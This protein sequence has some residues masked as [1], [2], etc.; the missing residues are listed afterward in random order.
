MLFLHFQRHSLLDG[1]N[2]VSRTARRHEHCPVTLALAEQEDS[3]L[4]GID[5][6]KLPALRRRQ[7]MN[8]MEALQP[9]PTCLLLLKDPCEGM[10]IN[11][12]WY[13]NFEFH[14][15][16]PSVDLSCWPQTR[17]SL[18]SLCISQGLQ[19]G[20]IWES[21]ASWTLALPTSNTSFLQALTD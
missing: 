6:E 17:S 7:S 15:R 9:S 4:T 19:E 3:S 8:Q 10:S 12:H 2:L 13:I 14:C 18:L 1:L 11:R 21:P 5:K 20:S 16:C